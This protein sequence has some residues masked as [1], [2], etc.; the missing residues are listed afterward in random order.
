MKNSQ[1]H[2]ARETLASQEDCCLRI[3]DFHMIRRGLFLYLF[4]KSR[5]FIAAEMTFDELVDK[6]S[7]IITS[8]A[9]DEHFLDAACATQEEVTAVGLDLS[10]W[11]EVALALND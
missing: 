7:D 4:A 11:V 8:V 5:R 9:V 2:V 6:A 3:V 1:A 10:T